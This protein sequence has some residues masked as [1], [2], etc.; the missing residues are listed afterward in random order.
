MSTIPPAPAVRPRLARRRNVA[1]AAVLALAI[2]G[3]IGGVL[4]VSMHPDEGPAPLPARVSPLL[5]DLVVAPFSEFTGARDLG[6]NER[7]RFGVIIGN[8]GAG[9]FK[10]RARRSAFFTDDWAVVQQVDEAGGGFTARTTPATLVYGGDG[11]EHW[12]IKQVERHTL[13]TLDG[14]VLG[15]VVKQGYCFF[16]TN[17]LGLDV[18]RTP[19]EPV[20]S[21]RGCGGKGDSVATMG[22]SVGWGDEYPWH[23]FDQ[24]IDVTS[25]P[26]G[27]YRLRAVVDPFGWFEELDETNNEYW[28]EFE[29]TRDEFGLPAVKVLR[30]SRD[31]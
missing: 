15:E 25:V 24:Q 13:E 21:S 5:P 9:D 16:D 8:E 27:T 30:T 18:P 28:E 22:L 3:T 29:L 12:H 10:L 26:D 7:L 14:E 1:I 6:G 17:P 31:G 19:S 23:M 4:Y 20:W 2:A 11:H